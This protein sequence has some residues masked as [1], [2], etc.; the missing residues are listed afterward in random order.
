[1]MPRHRLRSATPR[2][3][4]PLSDQRGERQLGDGPA[5]TARSRPPPQV[6][7]EGTENRA[8]CRHPDGVLRWQRE[9]A[10]PAPEVVLWYSFE[11]FQ[12]TAIDTAAQTWSA[13]VRLQFRWL[14]PSVTPAQCEAVRELTRGDGWRSLLD[15]EW[16]AAVPP[17]WQPRPKILNAVE[18][19]MAAS[20]RVISMATS[21]PAQVVELL[22]VP[23]GLL[24]QLGS[25]TAAGPGTGAAAPAL[26]PLAFV[27]SLHGTATFRSRMQLHAFPFDT[28]S[29][30]VAVASLGNGRRVAIEKNPRTQSVLDAYTFMLDEWH[31][32]PP[33]WDQRRN[34]KRE[35]NVFHFQLQVGRRPGATMI[36]IV[37][38]LLL[39]TS[40]GWSAFALA[41]SNTA[42]R[43]GI[44]LTVVLTQVAFMS[45]TRDRLPHLPY[46]T[47]L[48]L[49]TT[50]GIALQCLLVLLVCSAAS[51]PELATPAGVSLA[52]RG[53]AVLWAL[54]GMYCLGA[55]LEHTSR[56]EGASLMSSTWFG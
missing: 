28:Q 14:D 19:T 22:P 20:F 48:D 13:D 37:L 35:P 53:L 16:P 36:T 2:S 10:G 34:D 3:A 24:A 45:F 30:N 38:P 27:Y 42:D 1:M 18:T 23:E 50:A 55:W 56:C 51:H 5:A 29:L 12:I 6:L 44:L 47:R 43:L 8:H 21:S 15:C 31:L 25:G 9:G 32:M 7:E 17:L 41:E 33:R 54:A 39:V 52:A 40:L 49:L 4:A 11:V 46:P 26:E